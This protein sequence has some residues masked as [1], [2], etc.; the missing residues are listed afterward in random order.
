MQA[1]AWTTPMRTPT[2]RRSVFPLPMKGTGD[3]DDARVASQGQASSYMKPLTTGSKRSKEVELRLLE[4][5]ERSDET[6]DPLVDLWTAERH[7]AAP[8]LRAMEHT[9]SPGL[10]IEEAEL[11]NMIDY[12][13]N[14]W[15][16][17]MSRLALVLFTKR[18]YDEAEFWC[19]QALAVKPWHFE[20]GRL[21]VAVY[22]RQNEFAKALQ[23]ARKHML[24]SFNPR[25]HDRRRKSWVEHVT[26][27]A[28]QILSE[29]EAA[30]AERI[31][32]DHLDECPVIGGEELC[33]G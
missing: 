8:I 21:L 9:C 3:H 2:S 25:T 6:I 12:Y 22:L 17:P 29:A 23:A 1:A 5:L 27:Q 10:K 33:W 19:R 11:R 31:I 18:R 20:A 30:A 13:G 32:D 26:K 14:E 7:D 4:H 28:R 24:P 15:A 16:E